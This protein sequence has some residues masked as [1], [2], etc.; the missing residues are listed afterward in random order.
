MEKY[1]LTDSSGQKA[2]LAYLQ[3]NSVK[4]VKYELEG[5]LRLVR[6]IDNYFNKERVFLI[7]ESQKIDD[8][9]QDR[10]VPT[11]QLT[12]FEIALTELLS[13]KGIDFNLL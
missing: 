3:D 4:P 10:A 7:P 12:Y 8:Y 6:K 13:V 1:K 2:T 5:D 11:S 9:R